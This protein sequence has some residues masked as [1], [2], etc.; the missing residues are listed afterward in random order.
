[1]MERSNLEFL[2]KAIV[3]KQGIEICREMLS[4]MISFSSSNHRFCTRDCLHCEMFFAFCN[5]D[6]S[7][8]YEID[9][10]KSDVSGGEDP[11]IDVSI[12]GVIGP[13]AL[14]RF[15]S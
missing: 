12:S 3:H 5:F 15:L 9:T 14:S 7:K 8:G 10:E 2:H 13:V 11:G 6:L 4:R 1:M